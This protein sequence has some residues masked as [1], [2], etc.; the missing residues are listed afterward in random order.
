M[1]SREEIESIL[2]TALERTAVCQ[3]DAGLQYRKILDE[4]A[5][6]SPSSKDIDRLMEAAETELAARGAMW[7][8]LGRFTDFSK[9]GI[10]PDD[11]QG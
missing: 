1:A 4:L 9:K 8:A 7:K 11:L 5:H 10:I 6:G 3:Q 2:R